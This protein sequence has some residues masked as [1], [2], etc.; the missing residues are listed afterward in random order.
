MKKKE[1]VRELSVALGEPMTISERLLETV[2]EVIAKQLVSGEV[3]RIPSFGAFQT[4]DTAERKGTNP[5]TGES[6]V[7]PASKRVSFKAS[8]V[9]KDSVK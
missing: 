3:V 7:I 6:I 5:A 1:L 9:L 8:S 4:K 2:F